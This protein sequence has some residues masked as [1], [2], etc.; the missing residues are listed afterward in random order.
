MSRIYFDPVI[1]EDKEAG[2]RAT[3][4]EY[5]DNGT[6][7]ARVTH[8]MTLHGAWIRHGD[9]AAAIDAAEHGMAIE[10]VTPVS[11]GWDHENRPNGL[12]W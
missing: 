12:A 8:R 5:D 3:I 9:F 1:L 6:E 2:V 10:D 7:S 4:I 11:T